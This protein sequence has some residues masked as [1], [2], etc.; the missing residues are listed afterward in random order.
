MTKREMNN[1]ENPPHKCS[2]LSEVMFPLM[3]FL[4]FVNVETERNECNNVEETV[5]NG[6]FYRSRNKNSQL[7]K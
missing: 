4:I 6:Y 3:Y 7:F 1:L 2:F 5:D